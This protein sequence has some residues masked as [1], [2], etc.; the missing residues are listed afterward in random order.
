MESSQ[1]SQE[2]SQT[3]SLP[4]G[5]KRLEEQRLKRLE[6]SIKKYNDKLVVKIN[7]TGGDDTLRNVIL[8][9]DNTDN[10][11]KLLKQ[12][13][14]DKIVETLTFLNNL[15][16]SEAKEKYRK[17]PV[18]DCRELVIK[19]YEFWIPKQCREC[20][21]IYNED[22]IVEYRNCFI[23]NSRMC[24]QCIPVET[25]GRNPTHVK[26]LLP[27]C[28]CC[29]EYFAYKEG[30]KD[31]ADTTRNKDVVEK[32]SL[33]ST[34][35]EGGEKI[36]V[37]A[38]VHTKDDADKIIVLEQDS[39]EATRIAAEEAARIAAEEAAA[40][41]AKRKLSGR[42]LMFK[43]LAALQFITDLNIDTK[44]PEKVCE[45]EP[46]LDNVPDIGKENVPN[47]V[48]EEA[49]E[50]SLLEAQLEVKG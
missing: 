4:C 2:Q 5:Q 12:I 11:P 19:S 8:A 41:E 22:E 36:L 48:A 3:Q 43:A 17:I 21:E 45:V 18:D 50:N 37:E 9:L 13:R 33:E 20:L 16:P 6:D 26:G 44:T 1:I 7:E 24:P 23:C 30:E 34:A 35:A 28:H 29:E 40:A 25:W 27:V 31:K 15:Q 47:K 42:N 46:V 49:L 14:K 32:N 39:E 10:A 38:E